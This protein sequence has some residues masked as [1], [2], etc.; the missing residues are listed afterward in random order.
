M[1]WSARNDDDRRVTWREWASWLV[2]PL[3]VAAVPK[4]IEVAHEE[5]KRR[6]AAPP[7]SSETKTEGA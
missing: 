5:W 6:H 2:A 3:V 4:L 7:A 1:S